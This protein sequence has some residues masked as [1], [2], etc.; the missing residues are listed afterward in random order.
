MIKM[1]LYLDDFML[2]ERVHVL[3]RRFMHLLFATVRYQGN[4]AR[5]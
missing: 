4:Q 3:D 5:F 2:Y 1:I